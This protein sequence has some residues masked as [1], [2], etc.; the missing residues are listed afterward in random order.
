MQ[1][2]E[3][4]IMIYVPTYFMY[5]H[6]YQIRGLLCFFLYDKPLSLHG[7]VHQARHVIYYSK[8]VMEQREVVV[9]W[10]QVRL[11]PDSVVCG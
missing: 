1:H 11:S 6:T 5:I 8:S 7:E 10:V 9:W 4:I 3:D 2:R